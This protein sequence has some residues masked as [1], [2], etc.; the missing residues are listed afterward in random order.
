MLKYKFNTVYKC[1]YL[2]C[3]C[4]IFIPY[5]KNLGNFSF[6]WR[7]QHDIWLVTRNSDRY[8]QLGFEPGT[9]ELCSKQ[10]PELVL[11]TETGLGCDELW[12]FYS[13]KNRYRF[14]VILSLNILLRVSVLLFWNI[15]DIFWKC[16]VL[17]RRFCIETIH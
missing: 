14:F 10:L 13:F 9:A 16:M 17:R 6:P 15:M 12:S 3:F 8:P 7:N 11:L 1:F 5:F 2:I 4:D